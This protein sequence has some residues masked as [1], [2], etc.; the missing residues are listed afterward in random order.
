MYCDEGHLTTEG[1]KAMYVSLRV[2]CTERFS[3]VLL[4]NVEQTELIIEDVVST[5]LLELFDTVQVENVTIHPPSDRPRHQG[6]V[7]WD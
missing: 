5:A 7:L 6:S 3:E 2:N 1:E 4:D